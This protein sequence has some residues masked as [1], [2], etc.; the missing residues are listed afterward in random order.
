L[1]RR[2]MTVIPPVNSVSDTRKIIVQSCD[3]D[4]APGT[5]VK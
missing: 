1:S 5:A 3:R 2:N 4:K